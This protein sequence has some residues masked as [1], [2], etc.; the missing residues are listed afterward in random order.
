[1]KPFK[2]NIIYLLITSALFLHSCKDF[3]EIDPPSDQLIS[4]TVYSSDETAISA[5]RGLYAQMMT[6]GNFASGAANSITR[7]VGLSS[8]EFNNFN[9][10]EFYT[11]FSTNN[12]TANNTILRSGLW[13]ASYQYIYFA[14]VILDNLKVSN[15]LS[16]STKEQLEGE[17]KFIRAYCHFYLTNLFGEVPIVLT[18]DYRINAVAFS[19]T[20]D[21]IY[22]QII[23]D[24]LE[25]KKLLKDAY[26]STERIR[27]NKWAATAFLA[28]VYLYHHEWANAIEQ[29]SEVIAKTDAYKIVDDLNQV[30]L[31]NSQETILQFAPTSASINTNEGALFILTSAPGTANQTTLSENLIQAFEPGDKR[32]ANWIGKFTSGTSSW[33]YPFKYKIKTGSTPRNEYS[34]VLRLA[35]QYLIRAEAFINLNQIEL[36]IGDLNVIRKRARPQPTVD[37]PIP[38]PDFSVNLSKADALTAI[39]KERRVEFFSEWGHRWLDLKR[40]NRADEVLKV[41]KGTNWQNTDILYPIPIT[42]LNN[43]P[44]LRQNIGYE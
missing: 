12:L 43:N 5:V 28:R 22:E 19:S 8:D 40:T 17:A 35:E 2:I 20:K 25:S 41:T 32:L 39:E 34:M 18:T 23:S 36:G 10:S 37:N 30:F 16:I 29:S 44:N 42:E 24:L 31:K 9:S 38:I 4:K 1:M 6:S 27:A 13:Q 26:P 7:L 21:K 3:V 11:Q 33:Y 14:N 15:Q